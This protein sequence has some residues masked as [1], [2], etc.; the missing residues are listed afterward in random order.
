MSESSE[1]QV[2]PRKDRFLSLERKIHKSEQK[3]GINSDFDRLLEASLFI[4]RN[5][6]N[7]F[8]ITGEPK[9]PERIFGNRA[10]LDYLSG[11]LYAKQ[12]GNQELSIDFIKELHKL[13]SKNSNT[14][15]AGS[16]RSYGVMGASY[17]DAKKPV[18]YK[19]EQVKAIEENPFLRFERVVTDNEKSNTGFIIYPHDESGALTQ[20]AITKD[21]EELC[22]WFN[23]EKKQQSYDP[24]K[25]AAQL[26]QKLVSLHPFLDNNGR[27]SRVVMNW[28]LEN[29]G[30]SPSVNDNPS[31][32][33]LTSD[34]EWVEIIRAGGKRYSEIKRRQLEFQKAGIES[35]T[36]LFDLGQDKAFYDYIFKYIRN[37]PPL[38]TNGDV[39]SHQKYEEF[40]EEF[41]K[42]MNK[43]QQYLQT[44]AKVE[45]S[46]GDRDVTHGGLISAE[47]IKYAQSP[48]FQTPNKDFKRELFTDIEVFRGGIIDEQI[49]D[50]QLIKMF[51]GYTAAGSGYRSLDQSDLA[52]T[53]N[54]EV[55]PQKI[56]ESMD[57]YN[58]M[59]ASLYF[60]KIHPE[61]K[62]PYSDFKP[63][64]KDLN[65][66]VTEHIGG[67]DAIWD[68][69]F[70]STSLDYRASKIWAKRFYSLSNQK[71]KH[72]V[73]FKVLL[74]REGVILTHGK[75][76]TGLTSTGISSEAEA[77]IAGG[78]QPNSIMEIELYDRNL[79]HSNP[80]LTAKRVVEEG[81]E[82]LVIEDRRG[83]FVV[84]RTYGY[85]PANMKFELAEEV[86]TEIP[87]TVPIVQPPE[88]VHAISYFE[89]IFEKTKK[90]Y[91]SP[92]QKNFYE[93]LNLNVIEIAK[94]H[95]NFKTKIFPDDLSKKIP[96]IYPI[97]ER[98]LEKSLNIIENTSFEVFFDKNEDKK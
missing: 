53:S 31:N 44:T 78:I 63:A 71:A 75:K 43:F 3:L 11:R 29:D 36:A 60:S 15:N 4:D 61:I 2:L 1:I 6:L 50:E 89:K 57:Y 23:N 74:P 37:A 22:N 17:D 12:Y 79:N 42:E 66:S 68:S 7:Y 67:G 45:T 20:E 70:V 27:L 84:K 13:L 47:F 97:E 10:W 98:K 46:V 77:L 85:N 80:G 64:I 34:N 48:N 69:P 83:Q 96:R 82:N 52:T 51:Q 59:F 24:Y 90:E 18:E 39:H 65:T 76:F 21:L 81:K 93:E 33:I 38:P 19:P 54:Q 30:E 88:V 95:K 73:L 8:L 55:K 14:K 26:Q 16:I 49:D 28:S 58:N 35:N 56:S 86:V 40:L 9:N 5:F 94:D 72:G 25:V 87:S 91:E 41:K 92:F 62:N 32:D